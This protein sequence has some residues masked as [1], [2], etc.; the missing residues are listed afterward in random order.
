M[1]FVRV[2]LWGLALPTT[3]GKDALGLRPKVPYWGEKVGCRKGIGRVIWS[4]TGS[5]GVKFLTGDLGWQLPMA[6]QW[7]SNWGSGG[8][9]KANRGC[10]QGTGLSLTGQDCPVCVSGVVG[11]LPKPGKNVSRRGF[12]QLLFSQ[13]KGNS[14]HCWK[15]RAWMLSLLLPDNLATNSC[16]PLHPTQPVA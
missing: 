9:G 13:N 7:P 11:L 6:P 4:S 8:K 10:G 5:L 15:S 2:V 16:P 1:T 14:L 3:L 12:L